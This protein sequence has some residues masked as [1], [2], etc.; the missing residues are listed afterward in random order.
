MFQ[1]SV[2]VVSD[3]PLPQTVFPAYL[4]EDDPMFDG[5]DDDLCSA[6][7]EAERTEPG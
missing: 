5:E 2:I 4:W 7:E 1:I 6:A 3:F